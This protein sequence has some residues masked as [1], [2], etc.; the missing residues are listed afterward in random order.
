M[1]TVDG[2]VA[3][4]IAVVSLVLALVDRLGRGFFLNQIGQQVSVSLAPIH[5]KLEVLDQK[6]GAHGERLSIA[7]ERARAHDALDVERGNTQAQALQRMQS[8][9]QELATG[10]HSNMG[11]LEGRVEVLVRQSEAQPR[12]GHDRAPV[13]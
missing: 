10:V 13:G 2:M 1:V 5:A 6:L 11:R 8:T 3:I 12:N 7:E 4:G 9:V